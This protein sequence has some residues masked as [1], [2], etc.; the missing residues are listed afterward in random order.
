MLKR[1]MPKEL[2]D[3][4]N[5]LQHTLHYKLDQNDFVLAIAKLKEFRENRRI[6]IKQQLDSIVP[7]LLEELTEFSRSKNIEDM[8]DALT[9]M[10][11]FIIN[12]VDYEPIILYDKVSS[13][14]RN[15]WLH[16]NIFIE[17]P[18]IMVMESLLWYSKHCKDSNIDVVSV[19]LTKLI[20]Y[21]LLL[22]YDP[23]KCLLEVSKHIL[24]R[25]QDKDQAKRWSTGIIAPDDLK[26][27]KDKNQDPYTLYYPDFSKAKL[28]KYPITIKVYN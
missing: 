13:N 19:I 27:L 6:A 22:G 20:E 9:D 5:Y 25:Q 23:I 14:V 8:L 10:M 28:D 24:S 26:W 7:N 21:I 3:M 11:V 12:S 2:L 16:V 17:K 15:I 4:G 18:V 1:H